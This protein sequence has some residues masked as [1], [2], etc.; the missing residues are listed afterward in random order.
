MTY[1]YQ[2]PVRWSDMDANGHVNN[3]IYSRYLEE[4]RMNAFADLVP[5]NPQDR[6]TSNFVV[7]EQTIKFT[8]PLVYRAE[9]VSVVMSVVEIRPV[10]FKL[11]CEIRDAD[12]VFVTATTHMVA[13]DS[14]MGRPRRL[15]SD[16]RTSLERYS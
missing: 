6:L 12:T 7:A 15:S 5:D 4:A 1:T 2:C 3:A 14:A 8:R 10:S 16:E 13:F 9:P 11:A